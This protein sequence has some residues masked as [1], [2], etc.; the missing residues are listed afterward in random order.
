MSRP[1]MD[2]P[3]PLHGSAS[4]SPSTTASGTWLARSLSRI[5]FSPKPTPQHPPQHQP[6]ASSSSLPT[7]PSSPAMPRLSRSL[8]TFSLRRHR[9]RHQQRRG[10]E[11][12]HGRHSHAAVAADGGDDGDARVAPPPRRF[13]WL[14]PFRR[15]RSSATIAPTGNTGH[16]ARITS[17]SETRSLPVTQGAPPEQAATPVTPAPHPTS[18]AHHPTPLSTQ[19]PLLLGMRRE[20]PPLPQQARP[21]PDPL[22]GVSSQLRL[23]RR[24]PAVRDS[25]IA[26]AADA[27]HSVQA[28]PPLHGTLRAGVDTSH[29][30]AAGHKPRASL[31]DKNGANSASS[32]TPTTAVSGDGQAA[33]KNPV[34]LMLAGTGHATPRERGSAAH[35]ERARREEHTG[36]TTTS[37]T[38]N[39]RTRRGS[40]R[41]RLLRFGRRSSRDAFTPSHDDDDGQQ[42]APAVS[43]SLP[44]P[45]HTSNNTSTP[46]RSLVPPRS[47]RRVID[48]DDDD[49][50]DGDGD[51]DDDDDVVDE[52]ETW[53][54]VPLEESDSL[55][56]A[57]RETCATLASDDG[58]STA[59]VASSNV[60]A[61][62]TKRGLGPLHLIAV[63]GNTTA[64]RRLLARASVHV[65]IA[66]A[67]GVT[68]FM[69]AVLSRQFKTAQLLLD[70]GAAID[71][72]DRHQ[73]TAV[74]WVIF[75]GI[76]KA[77]KW[78]LQRGADWTLVDDAQRT[79]LHW[80][81]DQRNHRCLALLLA[82]LNSAQARTTAA[83]SATASPTSSATARASSSA[84][85]AS[86]SSSSSTAMAAAAASPTSM[87]NM[88]DTQAMTPLAWACHHGH[89]AHIKLLLKHGADAT[90]PN[91]QGRVCMHHVVQ[92]S[93]PHCLQALFRAGVSGLFARDADGRTPLHLACMHGSIKTIK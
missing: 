33:N 73:R 35:G 25:G 49:D 37:I 58:Y 13:S 71:Y 51:D 88:V 40:T 85:H 63:E 2:E 54:A 43:S 12:R 61:T 27:D 20:L 91:A 52:E 38:A 39:E 6:S 5:F 30:G 87:L 11:H 72:R 7:S 75:N 28:H 44:T 46:A 70:S 53:T 47:A 83:A 74:H 90:I 42:P 3:P 8:T 82:R 77:L 24:L 10:R 56:Q 67:D 36:S 16:T 1:A 93:S 64:L 57:W 31:L 80:A 86:S 22:A 15:R 34:Q 17:T 23:P 59:S 26:A 45:S 84:T 19:Q 21:R 81:A 76:R 89:L 55:I 68:P 14:T 4:S 78:L 32:A 92:L 41:P 79:A 9:Q 66:D 65:D 50:G 60:S 18:H 62:R 29:D 48:D 69:L